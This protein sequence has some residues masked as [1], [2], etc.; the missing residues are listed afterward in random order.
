MRK[1]KNAV[2]LLPLISSQKI[3]GTESTR[4]SVMK[5]GMLMYKV[6]PADWSRLGRCRSRDEW[7]ETSACSVLSPHVLLTPRSRSRGL[8]QRKHPATLGTAQIQT[9]AG[10]FIG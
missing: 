6:E 7:K 4:A 1:T 5:F 8:W 10:H 2:R 3:T 9:L